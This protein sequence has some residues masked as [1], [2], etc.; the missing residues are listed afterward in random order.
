MITFGIRHHSKKMIVRSLGVVVGILLK[1]RFQAKSGLES[2]PAEL[3]QHL[4]DF[5]PNVQG[6]TLARLKDTKSILR[7]RDKRGSCLKVV[8]WQDENFKNALQ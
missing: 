8:L 6:L 1:L 3:V 5:E 4:V 7:E 2:I